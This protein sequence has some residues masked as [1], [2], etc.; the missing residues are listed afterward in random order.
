MAL[1]Y[2]VHIPLHRS[3]VDLDRKLRGGWFR[4]GPIL[5]RADR[6][7][8]DEGLYGLVH[9]RLPIDDRSPS[10][11]RRR[12]LRRNRERFRIEIGPARIDAARE[13]L[14]QAM[15]PRFMGFV[16]TELEP[17][18]HGVLRH[19]FDTRE[20]A[21]HD[22]DRLVAVSYFDVGRA[23][24]SSQL[25]LY[26]P[27]YRR[28]GLG[29]QT[30]LEEIEFGRSEG[31]RWLYPGYVVPGLPGFEYKLSVGPFQVLGADGRWRERRRPPKRVE[32]VERLRVRLDALDAAFR[33]E[34]VAFRRRFYPA[35]WLGSD[36]ADEIPERG[37]L[38]AIVHHRCGRRRRGRGPL[39]VE[40]SDADHR[41]VVAR[42]RVDPSQDLMEGLDRFEDPDGL[43]ELRALTYHQVLTR[44][45]T[46]REAA[47]AVREALTPGSP[48]MME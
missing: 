43:Y 44:A 5:L 22:G 36:L 11:S 33:A 30:L 41:F 10:R 25:G 37:H 20:V 15:K 46:A 16:S 18:V 32:A 28:F 9:V 8:I 19:I 31:L 35:C 42:T 48:G 17:L 3:Q 38:R 13:R 4:S 7:C 34:G 27:A 1:V 45:E 23:S 40:V 39:V 12:L 29:I 47:R 6:G 26:D 14:Y 24:L 2:D 21:I